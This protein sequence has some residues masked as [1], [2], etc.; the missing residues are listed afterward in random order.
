[1]TFLRHEFSS[2][3]NIHYFQTEELYCKSY[4][5]CNIEINKA[6]LLAQILTIFYP[7]LISI[8]KKI[9][10]YQSSRKNLAMKHFLLRI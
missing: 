8:L 2:S 7:F 5:I 10:N 3:T 6:N 9:M 4:E 1:M